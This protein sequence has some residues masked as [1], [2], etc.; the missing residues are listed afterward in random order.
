M[1]KTC[2]EHGRGVKGG[3]LPHVRGY[4]R[5]AA[6]RCTRNGR[7]PVL[8]A[9]IR[10]YLVFYGGAGLRGF[11]GFVKNP[12]FNRCEKPPGNGLYRFVTVFNGLCR[13]KLFLGGWSKN[14]TRKPGRGG[15]ESGNGGNGSQLRSHHQAQKSGG[16]G[17]ARLFLEGAQRL[18]M[19]NVKHPTFNSE[20]P[21]SNGC[22]AAKPLVKGVAG[23]AEDVLDFVA[24]EVFDL[25][26]GGAEVFAGIEFLGVFGKALCGWRR[27]WPG[28]GRC[29]C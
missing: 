1:Q 13:K 25:G 8:L 11:E 22:R 23:A 27:S 28:G 5:A 7:Q 4:G 29:Q 3:K 2:I 12:A 16:F 14:H 18:E 17:F 6:S 24:D 19:P 9:L 10:S 15:T 20:H 21:T 26:A